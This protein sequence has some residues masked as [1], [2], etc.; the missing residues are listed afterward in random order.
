[1]TNVWK[2]P[3]E[4]AAWVEKNCDRCFEPNEARARL[5]DQHG[6][7]HL[8]RSLAN[9]LPT[10]WTR[11]RNA[12]MGET[13][14]CDAFIDKPATI[15][16]KT[17]PA[18]TLPLIDVTPEDRNLIPVESWPDYQALQRKAKEGDHQ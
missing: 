2:N 15:R 10:P 5:T 6:C 8:M 9:K 18:D 13:Y 1:M 4:R 14:R 16:R 7:P 11:R 12:P 17:T 3:I